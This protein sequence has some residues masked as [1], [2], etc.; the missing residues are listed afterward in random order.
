MKFLKFILSLLAIIVT[1]TS[2]AVDFQYTYEGQT[3][4]YTIDGTNCMVKAGTSSSA[5]NIVSGNLIIPDVAFNGETGYPVTSIGYYAFRNCTNLNSITIPNSVT[6]IYDY[7]INGCT[8]LKNIIFEDGETKL[9]LGVKDYSSSYTYTGKGLFYDAPL[10]SV[11]LGRNLSYNSAQNYGYSPFYGQSKLVDV[12]FGEHVESVG[13]NLFK[14]CSSLESITIPNSVTSIGD[15]TFYGCTNLNSI[16]IPNSVTSIYNYAFNG[17]T[18]LKNI[19]FEDG[20][21]ELTLGAY[22]YSSNSTSTGKGLFY[23]APLESVYIGRNLSYNSE[24]NHGYS[25]F[26]GKTKLVD[27]IFGENV[28]SVGTN[29]FRRCREI[30]SITLPQSVKVIEEGAFMNCSKLTSIEM[31]RVA[32]IHKNAFSGCSSLENVNVGSTLRVLEDSAFQDCSSLKS[33]NLP[34]IALI[35]SSAFKNCSSLQ[36]VILGSDIRTIGAEAFSD[37]SAMKN[38]YVYS[39]EAPACETSSFTNVPVIADIHVVK[40]TRSQYVRDDVWNRF[41]VII[42]DLDGNEDPGDVNIEFSAIGMEND[43]L[44]LNIGQQR[45]INITIT[46]Q[47]IA[48]D[49]VWSSSDNEIASVDDHGI[50]TAN[51]VGTAT[52]TISTSTGITASIE[53]TVING[54]NGDVNGDGELTVADVITLSNYLIGLDVENFDPALADVNGDGEITFADAAMLSEKVVSY[55][56]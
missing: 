53:V 25:P 33:I 9:S 8:N 49:I 50:V 46:P 13:I 2:S 24:Q 51:N 28:E 55:K 42:D 44:R 3:L 45:K 20:E 38:I 54:M 31:S 41:A 1:L 40:G 16:T 35:Y 18:N 30:L 56:K 10:E 26:Y 23:D 34:T 11:Y 47:S 7:A 52:L 12:T 36:N 32:L 29:L 48:N 17:C 39:D 4:T 37:C 43:N 6:R 27:V 5:G 14:G 21:T 22:D 15:S 19:I